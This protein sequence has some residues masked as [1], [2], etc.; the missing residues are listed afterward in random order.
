MLSSAMR[1]PLRLLALAWPFLFCFTRPPSTN[2]WP[3]LA[4]WGCAA[5]LLA[6]ADARGRAASGTAPWC[7]VSARELA[8][9]LLCAALAASAIGLLQYFLGDPEIAGVQPSSPGQAIGNLRQRN[10]QASL[11]S[12]GALAVLWLFEQAPSTGA[13]PGKPRTQWLPAGLSAAALALLAAA[14]AATAS[15]TGALQ[16][17]LVVAMAALWPV[18]GERRSRDLALA[19]LVFHGLAAWA[20]PVVLQAWTGVIAEDLFTR[21]AAGSA[22]CNSRAVLWSNV[23]HLIA[24]K[25]WTG[26]GWGELDYAHYVTLFP[27]ERFCALL[28]NAH[29]LPLHL[30]VELG[31]PAAALFCAALLVWLLRSKPWSER[32]PG[33][34]LAWGVLALVGLHSLLEF[35][36]WYGPFQLVTWLALML[37]CRWPL[38]CGAAASV[39]RLGAALATG[40]AVALGA[41][42]GWDFY[43]VSQLYMPLDERAPSLR[44]DTVRKVGTTPFFT[45]QVDFALLP[46]V[47]PTQDNAGQVFAVAN[48]LLHFS[49]EPRVIEPLIESAILLGRD[50]DAAFH[51][52]RYRAA[53]P[54]DYARWLEVRGRTAPLRAQ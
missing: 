32:D 13:A 42:A 9:G 41:Y 19:A 22:D 34:Q 18:A 7:V 27:G 52:Q 12:L 43:R 49:P 44:N 40:A 10:Q 4:A 14:S 53:Y 35:P 5:L 37:L 45:D 8:A 16:W 25:P 20:L 50:D 48:K 21:F 36:L 29:N 1:T 47:R 33:R 46:N 54:A 17:L 31:L 15:R 26:W 28:D 3:L 39:L 2:F 51:M 38:P 24:Q 30:A 11:I 23:L 6:L